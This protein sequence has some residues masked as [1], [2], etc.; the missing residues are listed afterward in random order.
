MKSKKILEEWF[1][2]NI[3]YP[4]PSDKTKNEL[5]K[6][7]KLNV[8][9]ITNWF[10]ERRRKLKRK[11]SMVSNR[12]SIDKKIALQI[13]FKK[14]QKPGPLELSMIAKQLDLSQKR[15]SAWFAKERFK[16]KKN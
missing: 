8:K 10:V 13:F 1:T 2:N 7:S 3:Q 16:L 14:K 9:Q 6:L 4:Y 12:L 11:E 15:V 5:A